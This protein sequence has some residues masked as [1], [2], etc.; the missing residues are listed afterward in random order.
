MSRGGGWMNWRR[1]ADRRRVR[2]QSV[3]DVKSAAPFM[4]PIKQ[5]TSC[6]PRVDEA[7]KRWRARQ[8]PAS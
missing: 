8:R 1:G 7:D 5:P 2:R 6:R 4:A 3:E